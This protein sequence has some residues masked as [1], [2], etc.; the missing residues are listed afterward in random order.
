MSALRRLAHQ[1][2]AGLAVKAFTKYRGL[3]ST[4]IITEDEAMASLLASASTIASS[5]ASETIRRAFEV[6]RRKS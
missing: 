3:V 6:A 2:Y 5:D 4:G 1:P